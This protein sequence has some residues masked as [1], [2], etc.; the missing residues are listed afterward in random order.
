MKLTP[1]TK[2]EIDKMT[3]HQIYTMFRFHP[4]NMTSGE[5]GKYMQEL[6]REKIHSGKDKTL[7]EIRRKIFGIY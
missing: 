3:P 5:S 7:T 4:T 6:I 1:Q 2:S